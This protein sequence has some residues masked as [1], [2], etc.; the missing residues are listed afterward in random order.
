VIVPVD[1][2]AD[3]AIHYHQI[4]D[5]SMVETSMSMLVEF[6]YKIIHQSPQVLFGAHPLWP[7]FWLL[8]ERQVCKQIFELML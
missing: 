7:S 8:A 5:L 3:Q 6:S 2:A 1:G 4:I